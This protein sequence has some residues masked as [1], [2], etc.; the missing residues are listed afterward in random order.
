M[1]NRFTL[2]IKIIIFK[3]SITV[4]IRAKI[5]QCLYY[6]ASCFVI[7]IM[8]ISLV[9]VFF[10]QS[11]L[12]SHNNCIELLVT[13]LAF[14]SRCISILKFNIPLFNF[15]PIHI[16]YFFSFNINYL[17]LLIVVE[18]A[19]FQALNLQK[20]E[21]KM[22]YIRII[23]YMHNGISIINIHSVRRRSA[24]GKDAPFLDTVNYLLW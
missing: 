16:H 17:L 10:I 3:C 22:K 13:K 8:M 5:T 4:S 23:Q 2:Y 12:S 11:E 18:R 9:P 19:I 7:E 20:R 15:N 1:V 14:T 24:Y 6:K 21:E